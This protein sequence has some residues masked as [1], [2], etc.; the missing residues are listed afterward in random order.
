MC[1]DNEKTKKVAAKLKQVR[2]W[3]GCP[4][5]QIGGDTKRRVDASKC[6]GCGNKMPDNDGVYHDACAGHAKKNAKRDAK[7]GEKVDGMKSSHEINNTHLDKYGRNQLGKRYFGCGC[8]ADVGNTHGK[9]CSMAGQ[10]F[11]DKLKKGLE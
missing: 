4:L 6:I 8:N 3:A 10:R 2:K 7:I 5:N 9:F 1:D 11:S